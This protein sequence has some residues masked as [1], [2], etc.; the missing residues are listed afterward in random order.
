MQKRRVA[1]K[2]CGGL[3]WVDECPDVWQQKNNS[4]QCFMCEKSSTY[5]D[6]EIEMINL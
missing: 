6:N 1:C 5:T 3:Y 2:N 4:L